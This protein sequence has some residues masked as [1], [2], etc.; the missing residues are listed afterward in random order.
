MAAAFSA[1][2]QFHS[3]TRFDIKKFGNAPNDIVFKFMHDTVSI[4]H[5]PEIRDQLQT[6]F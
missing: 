1:A 3:I 4:D 5:V 2:L 6:L